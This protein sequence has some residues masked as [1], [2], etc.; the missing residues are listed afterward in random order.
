L[1]PRPRLFCKK[2]S[3][4][5]NS[6]SEKEMHTLPRNCTSRSLFSYLLHWHSPACKFS[7][8]VTHLRVYFKKSLHFSCYENQATTARV[9]IA[10]HWLGGGV[11]VQLPPE[12]HD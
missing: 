6:D 10:Y 7:T 9:L 5:N 4:E 3:T 12:G 1:C 8:L 11:D 2:N